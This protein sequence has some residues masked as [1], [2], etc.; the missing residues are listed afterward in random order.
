MAE[1]QPFFLR[2]IWYY[3]MPSAWLAAGKMAAKTLLG[4]PV[5]FAR[6][7]AGQVFAIKDICPHRAMPLSCGRFDGKVVECCY[8]GWT[9]DQNGTCTHIPWLT[10]HEEIDPTKIKV[11]TYPVHEAQGNIWIFMGEKPNSVPD[12]SQQQPPVLPGIAEAKPNVAVRKI[13]PCHIDH[14][15]IGLMDPAHGPFVHQSWWWRGRKSIYTKEKAFGPSPFGFVMKRHR[16]SKNSGAYK[17]LGGTP[18]TEIRFLLPGIRIEHTAIG[19][20]HVINLTAVTPVDENTT[21]ITHLI[22]WTQSWLSLLKPFLM[23]FVHGFLEQDRQVVIQQQQGLKHQKS[24][25][26]LKDADTQARWYFQ[27]KQEYKRAAEE[28]RIFNNPVPDVTLRWRS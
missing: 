10:G 15:V 27:L 20:Q 25:L 23:P 1:F 4:E 24:M 7:S 14:G 16:P 9:F 18:E 6:T 17:I 5:L 26:L 2:N 22:Y 8:H 13:F 12:A 21:E 11:A 3:A 28:A 19:N